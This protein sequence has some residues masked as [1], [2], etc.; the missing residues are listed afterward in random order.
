MS[1]IYNERQWASRER[2]WAVM[3]LLCT[4]GVRCRGP[5]KVYQGVD[6]VESG[7]SDHNSHGQVNDLRQQKYDLSGWAHRYRDEKC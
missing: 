4:E 6:K 2:W 7:T 5:A 3:L 1:A